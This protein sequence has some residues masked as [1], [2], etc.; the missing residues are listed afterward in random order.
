MNV[1]AAVQRAWIESKEQRER[2]SGIRKTLKEFG[3]T[4]T[5]GARY[6]GWAT[7]GIIAVL[8]LAVCLIPQGWWPKSLSS[9][10]IKDVKAL[11]I[12]LGALYLGFQQWR[13][14]RS[15]VSL[16]TFW[17]RLSASNDKLDDW[18]EV[19]PFAGP[20]EIDGRDDEAAYR[21]RM[22]VYLEL[23]SLE[24]AVGKYRIGYINSEDAYRS[25]N[26]FRHRCL[27]SSKFCDLVL[28][29][30]RNYACDQETRSVVR[31][32]YEWRKN[33]CQWSRD[34]DYHRIRNNHGNWRHKEPDVAYLTYP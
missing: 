28:E 18:P 9:G 26:T 10:L 8:A 20:W 32:T 13:A 5:F 27:T 21:R 17:N 14:A 12:G 4:R 30:V 29:S 34:R 31:Q 3:F 33:P 23:D 15:E 22:Y 7:I 25:L 16:D 24:Y 1:S 11:I 19:R 2:R 6:G